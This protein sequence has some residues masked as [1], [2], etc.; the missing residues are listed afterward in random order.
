MARTG[1]RLFAAQ[2]Y[3]ATPLM[4]VVDEAGASRGSIYFHFPGG[5]EE[6]AIEALGLSTAKAL[7]DA[8][9]AIQASSSTADAVALTAAGLASS[10]EA[11]QYTMGCPV[12]TVALETASTNE[13]LRAVCQ[14]FLTK[15][16]ALYVGSLLRDGASPDRA[17]RLA[18]LIV[19]VIEGGLLLARTSQNS[20]PLLDAGEEAAAL[21]RATFGSSTRTPRTGQ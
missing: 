15:W 4:Q 5:K 7:T 9:T 17:E 3:E 16:Q 14:E 8:A 18:T 2:G 21:L 6:L 1:A 13:A 10:L 12:A 19:S 11:T 20:Q